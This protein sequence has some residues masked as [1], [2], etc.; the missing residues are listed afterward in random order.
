MHD[1]HG[2]AAP[3]GECVYVRISVKSQAKLCYIVKFT[4]IILH[5]VLEGTSSR[6]TTIVNCCIKHSPTQNLPRLH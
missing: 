6:M 2:C 3:E 1:S 4:Y 5:I